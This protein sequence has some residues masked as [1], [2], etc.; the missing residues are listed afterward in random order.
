M[1]QTSHAAQ[2]VTAS[3]GGVSEAA[4]KTG[5][6][7]SQVMSAASDLSKQAEQ[8]ST[9]VTSFVAGVRAA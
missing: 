6:A 3:I 2:E 1:Q 4:T 7:A 5:A 8:L 9:E